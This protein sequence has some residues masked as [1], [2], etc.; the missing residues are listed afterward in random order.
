MKKRI[1]KI[2]IFMLAALILGNVVLSVSA[3][4][5]RTDSR[6]GHTNR[7]TGEYH[8]HHGYSAHDHY[9]MD[10]D[11]IK[12]CPYDFRDNKQDKSGKSTAIDHQ[13]KEDS[14]LFSRVLSFLIDLFMAIALGFS[15]T[16][17]ILQILNAVFGIDL[18][19]SIIMFLFSVISAVFYILIF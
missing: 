18:N 3:H 13:N 10:G 7:S 14:S 15:V 9:D 4:S 8:Y 16:V 11:G 17:A 5:G 12:D 6:G 2:S 1:W 19:F